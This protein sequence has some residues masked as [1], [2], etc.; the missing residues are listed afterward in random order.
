MCLKYLRS[1]FT[2]SANPW[3]LTPLLTRKPDG[4]NLAFFRRRTNPD[5]RHAQLSMACHVEGRQGLRKSRFQGTHVANRTAQGA[6][7]DDWVAHQLTGPVV[8]NLATAVDFMHGEVELGEGLAIEEDVVHAA[9]A[10]QGVDV[11]VLQKQHRVSDAV[12]L[13]QLH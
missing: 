13:S 3:L 5:A 11:R 1:V 12:L 10:A 8:G 9:P 6:N 7:V 4:G 2:L